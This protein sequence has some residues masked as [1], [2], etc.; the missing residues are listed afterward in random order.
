MKSDLTRR[1]FL[2]MTGTG[3]AIAVVG[4]IFANVALS[5]LL[6]GLFGLRDALTEISSGQGDLTRKLTVAANDEIGQT[7]GGCARAQR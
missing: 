7:A 4:V 5:S 6:K 3:L 2:K 1:Q